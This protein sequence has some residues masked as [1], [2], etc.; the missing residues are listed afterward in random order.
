MH[1]FGVGDSITKQ[2]PPWNCLKSAIPVPP[3]GKG[4]FCVLPLELAFAYC[5]HLQAEK[6]V[7]IG[8]LPPI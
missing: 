3:L 5:L 8:V 2:Y 7:N 4:G 1:R 6:F